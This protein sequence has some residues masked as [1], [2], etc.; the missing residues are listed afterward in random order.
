MFSPNSVEVRLLAPACAA[1]EGEE[2]D[3]EEKLLPAVQAAV[4]F[5]IGGYFPAGSSHS[6]LF[7][8]GVFVR[9]PVF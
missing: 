3:K 6:S 5:S 8:V 1:V 7:L 4:G 9:P 2:G